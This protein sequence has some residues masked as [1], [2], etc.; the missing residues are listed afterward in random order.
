MRLRQLG[1]GVQ[2]LEAGPFL[3]L[4]SQSVPVA[5]VD[6]RPEAMAPGVFRSDGYFG[7]ATTRHQNKWLNPKRPYAVLPHELVV[8]AFE[9]IS[10]YTTT[11]AEGTH[12]RL[13]P[14]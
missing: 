4:L 1:F 14:W 3:F 10:R 6:R 8:Q 12:R 5:Y 7:K 9:Q 11:P 13:V 2:E